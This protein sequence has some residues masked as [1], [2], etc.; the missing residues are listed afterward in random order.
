MD[1]HSF[2]QERLFREAWNAVRI[3]RPVYLTLFTFGKTE[4]PYYLVCEAPQEG[5]KVS[6]TRGDVRIDR[7][8]IVTPD[9]ARPELQGFFEG[10]SDED[11]ARF[12]LARTAHFSNLRLANR[13]G[14]RRFVADSVDA[15][16]ARLNR[17]L[18]TEQEDRVAILVAPEKLGGI[19]VLR[20]AAERVWQSAPGNIQELRE[21][22]FLPD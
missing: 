8:R 13:S 4:L 14:D 15:T 11:I 17:K 2:D 12:L 20:Y 16:V 10:R 5:G 6:V 21:R 3:E 19:A 22:G 1:F 7:P 9:N 18:D